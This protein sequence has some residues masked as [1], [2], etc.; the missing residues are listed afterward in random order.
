M[1][2]LPNV[3][4]PESYDDSLSVEVETVILDANAFSFTQNGSSVA[5]FELPRKAVLD[6]N[7]DL[8]INVATD[9][10]VDNYATLPK[11][12][13][14]LV[15]VK[16]CSISVGG[17]VLQAVEQAGQYIYLKEYSFQPF[18]FRRGVSDVRLNCDSSYSI[19][20]DGFCAFDTEKSYRKGISSAGGA[21]VL[22]P[23]SDLLPMLQD[24]ELPT[25]MLNHNIMVEFQFETVWDNVFT[26]SGAGWNAGNK[27]FTIS[28]PRLLL[29][30]V[31]YPPQIIE[32]FNQLVQSSGIAI[33]YRD[34]VLVKKDHLNASTQTS[35]DIG[36]AK[37]LVA[38]IF[39]QKLD[40]TAVAPALI[41]SRKKFQ[42]TLRS[43]FRPGE[44]Y[45][46]QVNNRQLYPLDI[47]NSAEK[48]TYLSQA[49]PRP[50]RCFPGWY[51]RNGPDATAGNNEW[52]DDID[53]AGIKHTGTRNL[54][55]SQ[56]YLGVN[57]GRFRPQDDSP[58]NAT[59]ISETPIQIIYNT[60]VN[61]PCSLTY[62]VEKMR[63]ALV[64]GG[65]IVVRA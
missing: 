1:S 53:I 2:V 22:I 12:G 7:C 6:K 52:N 32:N 49:N 58:Q 3:L 39:V 54:Q 46:L 11:L 18:E 14:A 15:L 63:S 26:E 38:K 5:R 36:M 59:A 23:L 24:V 10:V 28:R 16:R 8:V 43:D 60:T 27:N 40:S 33:P 51:E 9:V 56:S 37:E 35:H 61:N 29:D 50:F 64:I 55:G 4:N 21:E 25:G 34:M 20:Q 42:K 62:Y 31:H 17:K 48:Y 47:S 19:D 65:E 41:V 44:S 45:N 13:G 57:L 30:F